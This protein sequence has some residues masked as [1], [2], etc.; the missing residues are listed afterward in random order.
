MKRAFRALKIFIILVLIISGVTQLPPFQTAILNYA[1]D[2]ATESLGLDMDV[3]A[4]E[5][6]LF[7][8]TLT[9]SDLTCNT[10]GAEVLCSTLDLK[11]KGANS[12]GVSE[13]GK[14]RLDGVRF[15]ADSLEQ[16]YDAF[17][18]DS[19]GEYSRR[20]MLFE[21]FEMSNFEWF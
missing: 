1:T 12:E 6:H 18:S 9:L 5:I 8:R 15:F 19:T 16:I 17:P 10:G 13:F 4:V 14:I 7:Q 21:R 2:I 3:G 20:K 11:Y